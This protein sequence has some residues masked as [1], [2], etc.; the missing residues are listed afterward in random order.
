M[1]Y[2]LLRESG[3]GSTIEPMVTAKVEDSRPVMR[4]AG[5]RIDPGLREHITL[6]RREAPGTHTSRGLIQF[7]LIC[8]G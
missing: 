1:T 4:R 7:C 2:A 3:N 6:C 8:H 5:E